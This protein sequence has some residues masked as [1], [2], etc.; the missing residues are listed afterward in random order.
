MEYV[1]MHFGS[2]ENNAVRI[3]EKII[4]NKEKEKDKS[5]DDLVM[6]IG[7]MYSNRYFNNSVK[8]K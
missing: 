1:S 8:A 6:M 2:I 5:Y 7:Y 3:D 4:F